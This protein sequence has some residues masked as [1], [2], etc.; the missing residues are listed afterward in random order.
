ILAAGMFPL[1][2]VVGMG[3][4]ETAWRAS[5][6]AVV[7]SVTFLTVLFT[8]GLRWQVVTFASL[9]ALALWS[10][11]FTKIGVEFI[12]PLDEG[13]MMDMPVTA[14]RVSLTQAADDLKARDSLW[15]SFPEVESVVGKAGRAGTA[16]DPA[17]L[18]MVETFVNFR[19]RELWPR[20]VLNFKDAEWQTRQVLG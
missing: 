14:P 3:A 2:A 17:G 4:S 5:F 13:S 11:H 20:R 15:R 12:P 8:R 1:Q 16:T 18:D 7:G 9:L 10:Y 6:L 19:P